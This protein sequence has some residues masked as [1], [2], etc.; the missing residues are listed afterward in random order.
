MSELA[1]ALLKAETRS[2]PD[3]GHQ[4]RLLPA[5]LLLPGAQRR[6]G[7]ARLL[8]PAGGRDAQPPAEQPRQRRD[9]RTR[10]A[11]PRSP[12][13][14]A[15]LLTSMC[16]PRRRG[17]GRAASPP[18]G[19]SD[20]GRPRAPWP[21]IEPLLGSVLRGDS[22]G[23]RGGRHRESF[24]PFK[25]RKLGLMLSPGPLPALPP[26]AAHWPPGERGGPGRGAGN[27]A[28]IRTAPHRPAP[29]PAPRRCPSLPPGLK[30][31][32]GC[33]GSAGAAGCAAGVGPQ[34]LHAQKRGIKR[35][36]RK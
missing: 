15:R 32:G 21:R 1:A 20:R 13:P 29:P 17:R 4:L 24:I 10:A 14:R 2:F 35:G 30:L 34:R 25:V 33:W 23:R 5:Q 6:A 22:P 36:G 28:P 19:G 9:R 18:A 26:P 27:C 11:L 12:R 16:R 3:G 31:L 7:A 8:R